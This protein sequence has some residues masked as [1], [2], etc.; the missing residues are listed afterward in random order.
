MDKSGTVSTATLI[1]VYD[2]PQSVASTTSQPNLDHL[3][4]PV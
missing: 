3:V 2:P 4:R 1:G